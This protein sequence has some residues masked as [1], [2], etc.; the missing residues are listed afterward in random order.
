MQ[1]CD[2]NCFIFVIKKYQKKYQMEVLGPDD[3]LYVCRAPA[4]TCVSLFYHMRPHARASCENS[5]YIFS[6]VPL[7]LLQKRWMKAHQKECT[8]NLICS[9]FHLKKNYEIAL[10]SADCDNS[11]NNSSPGFYLPVKLYFKKDQ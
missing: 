3:E 7:S 5:V 11:R 6:D 1:F 10:S 4:D 8:V 9:Q 2:S